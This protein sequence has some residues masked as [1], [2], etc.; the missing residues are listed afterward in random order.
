M[1]KLLR[2]IFFIFTFFII[3]NN[4]IYAKNIRV[5]DFQYLI[6]N[7]KDYIKFIDSV[8]D[9]QNKHTKN[10][11]ETETNLKS[12][13]EKLEDLKLILSQNELKK[14]SDIYNKNLNDFNIL[15][16]SFN[17][18]Y[19]TQIIKIKDTI[20]N[21]IIELLQEY[22]SQNQIDLIL[23]SSNYIIA[24]N[25]INITEIILKEIN[26]INFDINFETF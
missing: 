26:K 22:S 14:E 1:S 19:E 20:I 8:K 21:K 6:N 24:S 25:S 10:F 23:D 9:D 2:I 4:N 3:F 17:N 7:Q 5:V 18:H 11:K 12:Q 13:L 16:Q 15:I